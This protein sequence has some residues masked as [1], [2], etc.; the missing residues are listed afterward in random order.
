[1]G[2]EQK[3]FDPSKMKLLNFDQYPWHGT[4]S[5]L[6]CNNAVE[7]LNNAL[8]KRVSLKGR[9]H[10]ETLVSAIGCIAGY[11]TKQAT[12]NRMKIEGIP[13]EPPEINI[14]TIK[15]KKN[16]LYAERINQ[17]FFKDMNAVSGKFSFWGFVSGPALEICGEPAALPKLED[18]FTHVTEQI[19]TEQA[20]LSVGDYGQPF[21]PP[22]Q[23][24]KATWPIGAAYLAQK[25][26]IGS[27]IV[28]PPITN[29][30]P[31]I[32]GCVANGIIYKVKDVL[33]PSSAYTICMES[34]IYCSKIIS[35]EGVDSAPAPQDQSPSRPQTEKIKPIKASKSFGRRS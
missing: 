7:S 6:A 15:N 9:I 23:L 30:W 2:N 5:M 27:T 25:Q 13:L 11:A 19:A 29:Y 20:E 22:E 21:L 24:L 33:N 3:I 18:M 10:A 32:C 31:I 35:I 17:A 8:L 16:Y 1:M 4:E 34:A 14:V 12:L 26:K 28:D